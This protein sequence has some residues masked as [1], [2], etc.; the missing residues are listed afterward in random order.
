MSTHALCTI[1]I[2][3]SFAGIELEALSSEPLEEEGT[4]SYLSGL[5]D[6]TDAAPIEVNNICG[7]LKHVYNS[8]M[9]NTNE[10]K[11]AAK[12]QVAGS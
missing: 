3:D 12:A 2:T 1:L 9:Q 5:P 6:F 4:P 8:S 7:F 10:V 11:E